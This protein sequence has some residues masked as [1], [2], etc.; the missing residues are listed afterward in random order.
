MKTDSKR[1]TMH[2]QEIKRLPGLAEF[3]STIRAKGTLS[4]TVY[5]ERGRPKKSNKLKRLMPHKAIVGD[6]E[7]LVGPSKAKRR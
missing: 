6:P 5:E 7:K 2:K 1:L 4:E 3:R